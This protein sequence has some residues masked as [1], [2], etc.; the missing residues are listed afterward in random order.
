MKLSGRLL[1]ENTRKKIKLN[2]VIVL[3]IVLIIESNGLHFLSSLLLQWNSVNTDTKRTCL[4]VRTIWV[5]RIKRAL[6]KKH[7]HF[8]NYLKTKADIFTRRRLIS[9]S[10]L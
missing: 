9:L 3:V 7:G 2:L 1:F 10:W 8:F 5:F 4:S 6:G